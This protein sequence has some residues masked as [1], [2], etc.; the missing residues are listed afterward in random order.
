MENILLI[1]LSLV[2]TKNGI[3]N[4][5]K[6][7]NSVEADVETTNESAVRYLL[8]NY[9][10]NSGELSKIFIFAS[11]GVQEN[12]S[13]LDSP[14]THLQYFKNR[15]KKFLPNAETCITDE[16]IYSYNEKGT[17]IQSLKSVAE[18]AESIQ[19][20]AAEVKKNSGKE[21]C[22]HVDLSGGMRHIN[23]MM[24]DV[25]RLLEYSG[26]KIG[27]LLYSN[28]DHK[29]GIV[30]VEEVK[31]I[32]DLFQL[33]SGVEEF[34]NFGSVEVLNDYYNRHEDKVK[35]SSNLKKL[36]VAMKNFAEE[37]KLCHYG[38]FRKSVQE[39]HNAIN[40]FSADP[41]NL[42][43]IFM[44]RLI[45]RVR[46]DY[47]LLLETRGIDDLK[48][49]RWCIEKGYLQQALTLYTE[50]VPEYLGEKHFI[51]LTREEYGKLR[52]AKGK[53][54]R[55][56]IFY[57]LNV[58]MD[59]DEEFLETLK[60]LQKEIDDFNK[61]FIVDKLKG[62]AFGMMKKKIFDFDLWFAKIEEY[63]DK[64][65]QESQGKR[66]PVSKGD[67]VC[68]D[69]IKLREQLELLSELQKNSDPLA[70]LKSEELKPVEHIIQMNL[71]ELKN[72]R[73]PFNRY[74]EIIKF[75]RAAD[76]NRIRKFNYFPLFDCIK[77]TP[78]LRLKFMLD[79]QIFLLEIPEE[80]FFGIMDKYFKLKTERNHSNHAH[81]DLGDFKTA[82]GLED[83]MKK[84]LDEIEDAQKNLAK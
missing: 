6:Y 54:L 60:S 25:T 40:D 17:D 69:K 65:F 1:F 38:Q 46:E 63:G 79:R 58:Y 66:F 19:K 53:D 39:L 74:K 28:L 68:S 22:L 14:I 70:N 77:N 52:Q 56:D 76:M 57:L 62:N 61:K 43:D 49:I 75:I 67:I 51:K 84:A 15:M 50:R 16:T 20:F 55:N 12:I 73:E 10:K 9:L 21:V 13:E 32:Y 71:T 4:K 8:Q 45:G 24:L 2:K 29:N 47:K 34:V 44:A 82:K 31:N 33:I 27:H 48:I 72:I 36:T 26:V 5:F 83:F 3:V 30:K 80:K 35:L 18:M 81:Q 37:I 11:Q 78:L 42:H 64:I 7:E 41:E 23:M 59:K